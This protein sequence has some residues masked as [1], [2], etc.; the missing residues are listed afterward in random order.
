MSIA[1]GLLAVALTGEAPPVSYTVKFVDIHGLQWRGDLFH[2]LRPVPREGV[3]AWLADREAIQALT[4]RVQADPTSSL[5]QAPRV[6]ADEGAPALV[7]TG[8]TI[9]YIAGLERIADG[10]PLKASKVSFLPREGQVKEGLRATLAARADGEGM[11]VKVAAE[12]SRCLAMHTFRVTDGVAGATPQSRPTTLTGTVQVP[13]VETSRVEGEWAIPKGEFLIVSL[14]AHSP[15]GTRGKNAVRDRLVIIEATRSPA[16]AAP[17]AAQAAPVPA[18][19]EPDP[20]GPVAF[21]V[22]RIPLGTLLEARFLLSLDH[23]RELHRLVIGCPGF[24]LVY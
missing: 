14:G 22:V 24:G 21:S 18:A 10:P 9:H 8:S 12:E 11:L 16:D 23:A 17:K 20:R 6:T 4:D 1:L 5:T 7:E 13:E 3:T 15:G 19:P 2:Q